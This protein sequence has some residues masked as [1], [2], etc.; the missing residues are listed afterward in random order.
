MTME[1][2]VNVVRVRRKDSGTGRGSSARRP[3]RG[4]VCLLLSNILT[5]RSCC[6][7]QD[8]RFGISPFV[9]LAAILPSTPRLG[10]FIRLSCLRVKV[11]RSG[12]SFSSLETVELMAWE[13][14]NIIM[15]SKLQ[16]SIQIFSC[17][18]IKHH[19]YFRKMASSPRSP[20]DNTMLYNM[21]PGFR[22]RPSYRELPLWAVI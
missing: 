1:V 12:Q 15:H 2:T 5:L 8:S 19:T 18:N 3:G 21:C 6:R 10:V 13:Q 14:K 20:A 17:N 11:N 22:D 9:A 7:R 16:A 4:Y